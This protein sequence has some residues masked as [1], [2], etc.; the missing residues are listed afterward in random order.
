MCSREKP[1]DNRT[2]ALTCVT[3][4]DTKPNDTITSARPPATAPSPVA[5]LVRTPRKAFARPTKTK[6]KGIQAKTRPQ[7]NRWL[8]LCANCMAENITRTF[9]LDKHIISANPPCV[10][11]KSKRGRS[12]PAPLVID[13]TCNGTAKAAPFQTNYG[14]SISSIFPS[15]FRCSTLSLPSTSRKTKTSLSRNSASLTA[16]SSVMARMATESVLGTMCGSD[17]RA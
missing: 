12:Q 8:S 15:F 13:T 7:R 2:K 14:A 6:A 11:R 10:L 4:S 9:S 16:S 5:L 1:R 17:M 3:S